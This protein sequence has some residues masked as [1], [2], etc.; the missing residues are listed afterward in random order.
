MDKYVQMLDKN[1]GALG[2]TARVC[3]CVLRT[4]RTRE[5]ER[6]FCDLPIR[7]DE[8][9][10]VNQPLVFKRFFFRR[11]EGEPNPGSRELERRALKKETW[12]EIV[13]KRKKRR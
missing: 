7:R 2:Q 10:V 3:I 11:R 5:A 6:D 9:R 13:V 4:N 12:P 8:E 1:Y